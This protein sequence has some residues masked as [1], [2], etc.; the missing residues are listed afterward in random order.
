MHVVIVS[1]DEILDQEFVAV[2]AFFQVGKHGFQ[3]I[4]GVELENFFLAREFR[5]VVFRTAGRL[6]NDR[7][8]KRQIQFRFFLHVVNECLRVVHTGLLADVIEAVF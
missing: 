1:R 3:L 7:E 5:I 8:I 6:G 2:R 4:H